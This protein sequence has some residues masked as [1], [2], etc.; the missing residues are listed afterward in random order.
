MSEVVYIAAEKPGFIKTMWCE[1]PACELAMKEQAGLTA[2]CMP[3]A[4]ENISDVCPVCQKPAKVMVV[5][6]KAY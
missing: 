1:D 3:F 4:Q 6:G 5:W 2:R